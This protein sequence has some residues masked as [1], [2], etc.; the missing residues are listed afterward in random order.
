MNRISKYQ[1]MTLIEVIIALALLSIIIV[2][3]IN[4]LSFSYASIFANGFRSKAVLELQAVVDQLLD[5]NYG[6]DAAIRSTLDGKSCHEVA[7]LSD[8]DTQVGSNEIN[9]YVE[10]EQIKANVTGYE[11]TLLKFFNMGKQ[12][13]RITIFVIKEGG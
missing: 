3:L 9:Y 10:T 8:I 13:V 12:S 4:M 5:T 11:V 1:G 2:G 7:S 6:T